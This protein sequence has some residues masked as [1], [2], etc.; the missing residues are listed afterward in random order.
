MTCADA[1]KPPSHF[2]LPHTL[3]NW[4][5]PRTIHEDATGCQAE[6]RAWI[7]SFNVFPS[8]FQRVLDKTNPGLLCA[9]TA[10]HASL[11]TLRSCTDLMHIAFVIDGHT[12]NQPLDVVV[13]RCH[14]S[15]DA[16]LHPHQPRPVGEHIMGEI[17]RQ[18]WERASSEMPPLLIKR[19]EKTWRGYLDS[20]VT[21]AEHRDK[22]YI[23]SPKEYIDARRENVGAYPFYVLLEKSLGICLPDEVVDHPYIKALETGATDMIL[24]GND[25]CSYKK[26]FLSDDADYNYITVVKKHYNVDIQ[27]AYDILFTTHDEAVENFLS[28]AEKV[29][30]KDG[31]P[32]FGEI[33]DQQILDYI[34][35]LA[36]WVRGN[37]EWSFGTE[38]YFGKEGLDVQRHRKVVLQ[39]PAETQNHTRRWVIGW[40]VEICSSLFGY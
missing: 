3:H 7:T 19:F 18:Y 28:V 24:L 40:F 9:L 23:C 13:A 2:Y 20:V 1:S 33:V 37:D 30:N 26:E 39:P 10:P 22:Q 35:G 25:M 32:S 15:M 34:D 16:I 36:I 17:N 5:W 8:S 21:Q 11:F 27:G 31:F 4:P 6:S 12:D 38:R 29:R 14:E